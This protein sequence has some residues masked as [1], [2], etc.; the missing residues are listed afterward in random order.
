MNNNLFPKGHIYEDVYVIPTLI[1]KTKKIV[2]INEYLYNYVYRKNSIK[3]T[4][5]KIEDRIYAMNN[6][7]HKLNNLYKDEVEYLYIQNLL[8]T[9]LDEELRNHCKHNIKGINKIVKENYPKYYKNKYIRE[10]NVF[11]KIYILLIYYNF[12][13]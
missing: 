10:K 11:K 6:V 12:T 2:F 13:F 9:S 3:N 4:E 1:L 7:Y 5:N 8:I